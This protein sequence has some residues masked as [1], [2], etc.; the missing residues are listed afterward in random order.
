MDIHYNILLEVCTA[1]KLRNQADDWRQNMKY[2]CRG[3]SKRIF[4]KTLLNGLEKNNAD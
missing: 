4:K 2:I 1:G 3:V